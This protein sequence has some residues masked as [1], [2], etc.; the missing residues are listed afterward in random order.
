L[1]LDSG[2][3]VPGILPAC[4]NTRHAYPLDDDFDWL[5][6]RPVFKRIQIDVHFQRLLRE[7]ICWVAWFKQ[8]I[9]KLHVAVKTAEFDVFWIPFEAMYRPISCLIR[10]IWKRKGSRGSTEK[11]GVD[12]I[13]T[14]VIFSTSPA[15]EFDVYFVCSIMLVGKVI[16][17]P[18]NDVFIQFQ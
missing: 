5:S 9:T 6:R 7:H 18:E 17:H 8:E 3:C 11:T 10:E 2:L 15:T 12:S 16:E 14:Y 13:V 4:L 1:F